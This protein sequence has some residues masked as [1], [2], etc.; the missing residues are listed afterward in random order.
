MQAGKILVV[1]DDLDLRKNVVEFL[2]EEGYKTIE[3]ENGAVA[4]QHLEK[5]VPDLILSDVAMPIINGIDLLN[6][7]QAH[8]VLSMVPFI[9]AT[10]KN[11]DEYLRMMMNSG[12]DDYLIKPFKFKDLL[13]TI[14]TRLRKR[15]K[16]IHQLEELKVSISKHIPHE[17]RT[18]IVSIL[19]F[20]D[21]L[22]SD[23]DS[24]DKNEVM[25]AARSIK[26][27]G[28]RLRDRI[29][30]FLV[31]TE[32]ETIRTTIKQYEEIK[33]QT[34]FVEQSFIVVE[35]NNLIHH[36]ERTKDVH[37]SVESSR[38]NISERHFLILVRELLDNALKFSKSGTEVTITGLKTNGKYMLVI[39]DNGCGFDNEHIK[40][41]S[42]FFQFNKDE[43]QQ[44]GLGLGLAIVKRILEI[45]EGSLSIES[46]PG[47]FTQI[48]VSF[49]TTKQNNEQETHKDSSQPVY[50]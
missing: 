26:R 47:K 17:L 21:L 39:C 48:K 5:E 33:K 49:G 16:V 20:S 14:A 50:H 7:A 24:F 25:Q 9:F 37:V 18:P 29:E 15:A 11:D 30:K 35:M 38:I 19:G 13:N 1:E 44:P 4:I 27:A 31:F 43:M 46:L 32:V 41:I 22:I 34:L 10:G 42:A 28:L 45:Y 23:I 40:E 3:A 36:Y 8:P 6:Y 2:N 12:A